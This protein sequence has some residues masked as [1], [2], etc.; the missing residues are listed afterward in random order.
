MSP[1]V[2]GGGR[3]YHLR[4]ASVPI[5]DIQGARC[6]PS[7]AVLQTFATCPALGNSLALAGVRPLCLG[8]RP[9]SRVLAQGLGRPS[10]PFARWSTPPLL[11]ACCGPG[12]GRTLAFLI[13]R[14]PAR[15]SLCVS[16]Y[17]CSSS[18]RYVR[19]GSCQGLRVAP[20][21]LRGSLEWSAQGGLPT[22]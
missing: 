5:V 14:V 13:A 2:V 10:P 20:N 19:A 15:H 3:R 6:G 11:L 16:R 8:R 7:L 18:R 17:L 4:G 9:R 1:V 21:P 22:H 12:Q